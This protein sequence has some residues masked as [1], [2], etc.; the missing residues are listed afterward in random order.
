MTITLS[1]GTAGIRAPMGERNDQ[2][3]VRTVRAAAHAIVS[4]VLTVVPDARTRGLCLGFDGRRSSDLFAREVCAVALAEGMRVRWFTRPVPTPL[5][6]FCTRTLNAAVGVVVTAS[7]NPASDNGIKVYWEGGSQIRAPHDHAIARRIAGCDPDAVAT[8]LP[9]DPRAHRL[10]EVLGDAE[11]E[12][13]LDAVDGLIHAPTE[14]ELPRIAYTALGGVGGAITRRLFARLGITDV[15]E[16][17]EQAEPTP[18]LA[19]LSSPNPEHASA[20]VALRALAQH[21]QADLLFAHDPDADRLAVGVRTRAGALRILTGDEVGALL[22]DFMLTLHGPNALLVSTLVSGTMLEDIARA[23]GARYERVL[24]GFK[25]IAE[26]GRVL[27]QAESVP[28]VYGYEEAIGYGFG[29]LGDDKD[30]I[31]A[32][33]VVCELA[34]RLRREGRTL[35]DALDAQFRAHGLYATRQLTVMGDSA[36]IAA[37]VANARSLTA[38]SLLGDGATLVDYLLREEKSDLLVFA[39]PSGTRVAIRPSGTEP[40]LKMY[41]ETR[42]E[43]GNRETIDQARARAEHELDRLAQLLANQGVG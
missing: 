7:H 25:N 3:N 5:V 24:T 11:V 13:Y 36:T 18:D 29:A 37:L 23:R 6:A 12:R 41:L 17:N 15:V 39:H 27:E 28:F 40:K 30:G 4:H 14:A 22:G 35:E 19:G 16:V 34:R 21:K 32:L 31:A 38:E 8:L 26:R 42:V 43:V 20:L 9:D 2:L 10:V 1:F 33:R